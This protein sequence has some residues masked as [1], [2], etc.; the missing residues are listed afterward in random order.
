MISK[1]PDAR[2]LEEEKVRIE[3]RISQLSKK[4]S[5]MKYQHKRTINLDGVMG[6]MTGE[7]QQTQD[8]AVEELIAELPEAKQLKE[9]EARLATVMNQLAEISRLNNKLLS[10][11]ERMKSFSEARRLFINNLDATNEELVVIKG[12][13]ESFKSTEDEYLEAQKLL[14]FINE[15]IALKSKKIKRK[16]Q[17][18][19]NERFEAETAS[20]DDKGKRLKREHPG[21]T[22][23]E[24]DL[25]SKG[26]IKTG[27]IEEQVRAALGE[28]FSIKANSARSK[29]ILRENSTACVYFEGGVCVAIQQ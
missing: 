17:A 11:E 13:L 24:C 4:L 9:E 16:N 12:A 26:K 19:E 22:T 25:I 20:L 14:V 15:K 5:M 3:E 7:I 21:W 8:T 23:E 27:M 6:H 18:V 29:W 10:S 28:P 2:K 1:L